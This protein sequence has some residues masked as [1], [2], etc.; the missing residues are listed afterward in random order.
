MRILVT[1][2]MG[3]IGHNVATQLAAQGHT[4]RVVDNKTD[5]GIIPFDEL[6]YV[7]NERRKKIPADV[8]AHEIDI[9][10]PAAKFA[11]EQFLPEVVVHLA[12]FPRQKVVNKNPQ[13]GSRVMSEGLLNLLE[14]S[15]KHNIK[16]FV[17]ISS[18]MV[19]GDFKDQVREDAEC[20]PQGQYGILKLA[21]E[22]LVKDYSRRTGLSHVIVRP[23]AVYGPYD[24]EDRVVSKFLLTAMRDEEIQVNGSDEALDFT[25]VDDTAAGIVSA[26]LTESV[27]WGT[28][29]I[30]RGIGHTLLDAAELAVQIVG[31]GSIKINNRDL[32]FPSRGSLSIDAARR[33]LDYTPKFD[34][35]EGFR[36]YYHWLNNSVYWSKKTI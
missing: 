20:N 33:D 14:L 9:E 24:V 36:N 1:G 35:E 30:T 15:I 28:Y 12:S 25:Y 17:Y 8:I 27:T 13:L 23:S 11:F 32:N 2:G 6:S 26:A 31:K 21:G 7:M 34:I 18:S 19:Y 3:F 5:Y 16:K 22:W 4:V 29:N 10:S